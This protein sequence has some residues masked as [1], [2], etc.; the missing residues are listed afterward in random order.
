[1]GRIRINALFEINETI[2]M[3][4]SWIKDAPNSHLAAKHKYL[5]FQWKVRRSNLKKH[6]EKKH[7][8][9]R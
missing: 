1:M 4:E 5:R 2:G 7:D 6:I 8:Q 9:R 3:I